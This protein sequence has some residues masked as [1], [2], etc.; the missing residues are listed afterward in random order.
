MILYK[1]AKWIFCQLIDEK[2]DYFFRVDL[3]HQTVVCPIAKVCLFALDSTFLFLNVCHLYTTGRNSY[4][5]CCVIK[6]ISVSVSV[7]IS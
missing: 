7:W 2:P 3:L 5:T 6:K 4:L 1:K